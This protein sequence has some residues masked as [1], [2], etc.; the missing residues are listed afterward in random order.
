MGGSGWKCGAL[1]RA[2][3]WK[4]GAPERARAWNGG[5]RSE[6]EREMGAPKRARA[7]KWGPA[8]NSK[9]DVGGDERLNVN[10]FWKW[11]SP[12]RQKKKSI[13]ALQLIWWCSGANYFCHL[14]EWNAPEQ[15]FRAENRGL[16]RGTYLII[17][18]II[19]MEVPPG[20]NLSFNILCLFYNMNFWS[21]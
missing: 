4:W 16:S 10:K 6:L 21:S 17:M 18:C 13:S 1:E 8:V 19:Y 12:E 11:W 15:K 5:L 7:W 20:S 14:W 9:L 2:R 3:A